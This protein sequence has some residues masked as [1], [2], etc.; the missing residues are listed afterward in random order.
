VNVPLPASARSDYLGWTLERSKSTGSVLGPFYAVTD[1]TAATFDDGKADSALHSRTSE[2]IHGEPPHFEGVI[3]HK[4][5][6][7]GWTESLLYVSQPITGPE[8][9]GIFNWQGDLFFP[10]QKDDGDTIQTVL[11]QGERLVIL[12]SNSIHVL[13]GDDTDNFQLRAVYQGLGAAGPRAAATTGLVVWFASGNG[14]FNLL[15]GDR[16]LAIA[17]DELREYLADMDFTRDANVIVKNLI[18]DF[19]LFFYTAVPSTFN[20]DIVAFDLRQREWT[21]LTNWRCADALVQKDVSDFNRATLL[22]ADPKTIS[23]YHIWS[24]FNGTSDERT[25]A[26]T[27]GTAIPFSLEGPIIDDGYP[28]QDKDYEWLEAYIERGQANVVASLLLENGGVATVA[29]SSTADSPKY[30]TGLKYDNGVFYAREG[31]TTVGSGLPKGTIGRR[32]SVRI[33]A[34]TTDEF[35]FGGYSTRGFM[36]PTQRYS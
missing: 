33:T 21:H 35:V 28:D 25:S 10:V 20:E 22:L 2:V 9:T 11:I 36:L 3:G 23:G 5:R 16:V 7:F 26:G 14:R 8:A 4:G 15:D 30:D 13:E 1:G 24:V 17:D 6:L 27:G 12:K 31:K 34:N 32:Y 29:L 19:I 18:G